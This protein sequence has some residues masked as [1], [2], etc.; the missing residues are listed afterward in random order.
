MPGSDSSRKDCVQRRAKLSCNN[1]HGDSN[2]YTAS[3][4]EVDVSQNQDES[5]A[6]SK[7]DR[8]LSEDNDS[9]LSDEGSDLKTDVYHV[10]GS[11]TVSN[12]ASY[13]QRR[14]KGDHS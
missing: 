9:D 2:E 3:K 14:P 4:N 10:R 8:T 5:N 6:S 11:S 7:S 1:N 13:F 12:L